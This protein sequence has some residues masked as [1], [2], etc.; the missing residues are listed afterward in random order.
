MQAASVYIANATYHRAIDRL[1]AIVR[2]FD[3]TDPL[4]AGMVRT[5]I[6][7]AI[8]DE[9]NIWPIECSRLVDEVTTV[10]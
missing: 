9:F 2:S 8:G 1:E 3:P 10:A 7:E 4:A 6:I 5:N